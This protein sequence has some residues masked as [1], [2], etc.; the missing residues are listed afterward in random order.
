M[1]ELGKL[2]NWTLAFAGANTVQIEAVYAAY[3]DGY[4]SGED[5]TKLLIDSLGDSFNGYVQKNFPNRLQGQ[6]ISGAAVLHWF[7]QQRQH[8]I[9]DMGYNPAP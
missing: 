5:S 4:P 7:V 3:I 2:D 9:D 6:H 8:Y 1:V